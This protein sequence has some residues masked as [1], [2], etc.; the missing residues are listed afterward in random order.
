M[1]KVILVVTPEG[2]LIKSERAKALLSS[3]AFRSAVGARKFL[4]VNWPGAEV[5]GV[6]EGGWS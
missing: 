1:I 6:E 2:W 3:K 5:V 4:Q